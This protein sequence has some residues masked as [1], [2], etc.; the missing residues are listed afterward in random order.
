M[1]L[2]AQIHSKQKTTYRKQLK[3]TTEANELEK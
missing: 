2:K 3:D 1:Q